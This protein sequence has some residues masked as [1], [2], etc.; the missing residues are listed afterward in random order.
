MGSIA[1]KLSPQ[2]IQDVA[3]YYQQQHGSA[4]ASH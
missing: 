4:A 1:R 2:D 3:A